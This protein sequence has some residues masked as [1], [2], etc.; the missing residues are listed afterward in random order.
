MWKLSHVAL[1][2]GTCSKKHFRERKKRDLNLLPIDCEAHFLVPLSY[3]L[4]LSAAAI[5]Y[6]AGKGSSSTVAQWQSALLSNH[7]VVG[8]T[9][10][11][12]FICF[13]L[14]AFDVGSWQ[15][16]TFLVNSNIEIVSSTVHTNVILRVKKSYTLKGPYLPPSAEMFMGV[17]F[18]R[19]LIW[20]FSKMT[21][22]SRFN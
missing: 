4:C 6:N 14:F 9:S 20:R 2:R 17:F 5:F 15:T 12:R 22:V 1:L 10:A 19:L 7:E 21:R 8:S 3:N 13:F 11:S 16:W 18:N